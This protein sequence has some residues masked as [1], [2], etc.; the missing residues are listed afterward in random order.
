[1]L[2]VWAPRRALLD[3]G[4]SAS[5][6]GSLCS[7]AGGVSK[8]TWSRQ[9]GDSGGGGGGGGGGGSPF[10]NFPNGRLSLLLFL[11]Q[12]AALSI[13]GTRFPSPIFLCLR[14]RQ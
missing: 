7:E 3:Q 6:G 5:E 11:I 14:V 10:N 12:L 2:Q 9:N 8:E 13:L 1:M 4:K